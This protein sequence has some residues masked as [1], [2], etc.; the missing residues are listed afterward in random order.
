MEQCFVAV[1]TGSANPAW[2]S[3]RCR[4]YLGVDGVSM[5]R[6]INGE[7]IA[8]CCR[9]ILRKHD[10]TVD[11]SLDNS[12]AIFLANGRRV[13]ATLPVDAPRGARHRFC[14]PLNV[15]DLIVEGAALVAK[16]KPDSGSALVNR[17]WMVELVLD[18]T[19]WPVKDDGWK[20][21][22]HAATTAGK[23]VRSCAEKTHVVGIAARYPSRTACN[24]QKPL[25]GARRLPLLCSPKPQAFQRG[26]THDDV[27]L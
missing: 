3:T 9:L 5:C 6:S 17:S 22:T 15:N 24:H 14:V 11:L 27:L 21:S 20:G 23:M 2:H 1:R 16:Y 12:R 19:L 13:V 10:I 4:I 7:R 25:P 26:H 8:A 18:R